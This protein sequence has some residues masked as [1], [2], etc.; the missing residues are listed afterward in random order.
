MK[1]FFQKLILAAITVIAMQVQAGEVLGHISDETEPAVVEPANPP[2]N[3]RRI[4]YRVICDPAGEALPDCEQPVYDIETIAKPEKQLEEAMPV[5]SGQ[6]DAESEQMDAEPAP[7]KKTTQSKKTNSKKKSSSKKKTAGKTSKKSK[8]KKK[9]TKKT[10][11][12]KSSS[13]KK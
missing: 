13:Q 5:E 9:T 2:A 7:V 12:K 11:T 10:T 3:D 6:M 8:S 1:F 4:I